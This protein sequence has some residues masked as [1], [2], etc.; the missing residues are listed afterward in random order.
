MVAAGE[1]T[2]FDGMVALDELQRVFP[3]AALA[4]SGALENVLRIR[5]Q[6]FTRRM[7]EFVLPSQEVLAQRLLSSR[8]ELAELRRHL[9]DYHELLVRLRERIA[10]GSPTGA[11]G[12]ALLEFL[13]RGLGRILARQHDSLEASVIMLE[14]ITAHVTV[15]PSGRQF[16]VEGQESILQ[17]GLKNGAQ[18]GYGCGTGTCGLCKARLI[19]GDVRT[20]LHSDYRL[21][22]QEREQGYLLL[23]THTAVSDLV[24]ETLEAGGPQDI[25]RQ[26]IAA[27]VRTISPLGPD[28]LLLH[29]QTPRS[30]RLRFLAGQS[31][32]LGLAR[33][34]GDCTASLPLASC[35]CDERNLHFHVAR[36][37]SPFAALLF[38]GACRN[39]DKVSV[40]GPFGD[41]VIGPRENRPSIAFFAADTGFAPIK[42][43]IE[44][45]IAVDQFESIALYWLATRP[46][47]HY[48]ANQCR[49]WAQA[50]DQ[51]QFATSVDAD[52]AAGARALVRRT[53]A[54]RPDF[55][56]CVVYA[57]G[58]SAFV[59]SLR[60]ALAPAGL[61]PG[62]LFT[63]T[64]G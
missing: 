18:F 62:Q 39:G 56:R 27:T 32:T 49:A 54:E 7:Q 10:A 48:L 34:E 3:D 25:P 8:V 22:E 24:V 19:D 4:D 13:D 12:T 46:D 59:E 41:F 58:S 50:L 43:L 30:H 28:T 64:L 21:S 35:P 6:A 61:A 16:L 29:L 55:A 42:S 40:R 52:A 20:I 37:R 57:A 31:A 44:H 47:G 38:A 14:A 53:L 23:C 1:L 11:S 5:D 51:F 17:A 15:R 26:D 2:S 60:S 36:D 63:L 9:E 45:A 33:P